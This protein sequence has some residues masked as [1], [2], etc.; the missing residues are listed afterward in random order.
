MQLKNSLCSS[1]GSLQALAMQV[2]IEI[3]RLENTNGQHVYDLYSPKPW[4][5][6]QKRGIIDLL[7]WGGE[8]KG[9]DIQAKAFACLR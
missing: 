4:N 2:V 9:G 3:A 5:N 7:F 1:Y 6:L 8:V